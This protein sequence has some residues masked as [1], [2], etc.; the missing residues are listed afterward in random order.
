MIKPTFPIKVFFHEDGT[1]WVL[2]NE[3]ELC[4]NLEWFDSNDPNEKA[5]ITDN[6]GKEIFVVIEALE[7]KECCI[8]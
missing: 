3:D 5:S 4:S 6:N 1:E 2:N 8:K 7:L